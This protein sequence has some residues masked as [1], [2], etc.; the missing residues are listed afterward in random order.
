MNTSIFRNVSSRVASPVPGPSSTVKAFVAIGLLLPLVLFGMAWGF[1]TIVL[2]LLVQAA[3]RGNVIPVAL[4]L[5]PVSMP[6]GERFALSVPARRDGESVMQRGALILT[7]RRLRLMRRKR[8]VLDVPLTQIARLTVQG[9][10]LR[11]TIR[12][13]SDPVTL[14]VPQP[15]VI[16]RY[17]RTLAVQR[18]RTGAA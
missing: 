3:E 18:A 5:A 1:R 14:R 16:A 9:W 2:A 6:A 10:T 4:T 13:T 17:V 7:S 8:I 15:A 12:G 11:L